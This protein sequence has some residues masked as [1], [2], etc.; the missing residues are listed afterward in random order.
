[1]Q[2][3]SVMAGC[4]CSVATVVEGCKACMQDQHHRAGATRRLRVF[5]CVQEYTTRL[6][7]CRLCAVK[8][9]PSHAH[10]AAAYAMS[11]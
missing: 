5:P 6:P 10:H 2:H 1:M 7:G 11:S 8:G 9:V 4:C 3:S